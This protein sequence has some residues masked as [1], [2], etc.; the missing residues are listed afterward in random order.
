MILESWK[1]TSFLW[2]IRTHR[3]GMREVN[4]QQLR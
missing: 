2:S 4:S 3:E 1:W